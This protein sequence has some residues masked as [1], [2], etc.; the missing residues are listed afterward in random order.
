[1]CRARVNTALLVSFIFFGVEMAL[2]SFALPKYFLSFFFWLDI[3]GT[4]S[5]ILDIPWLFR[6]LGLEKLSTELG[7]VSGAKAARGARAA[8]AAKMARLVRLIRLVRFVRLLKFVAH[9]GR[10]N[11]DDQDTEAVQGAAPPSRIGEILA[12]Q[13]SQR[14]VILVSER[15]VAR[16]RGVACAPHTGLTTIM[17][18][19]FA[20]V[21]AASEGKLCSQRRAALRLAVNA[22]MPD[23]PRLAC[24]PPPGAASAVRGAASEHRPQ[25]R[26]PAADVTDVHGETGP[27]HAC[28]LH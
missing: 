11:K 23:S 6:N 13:M 17:V 15:S 4:V 7:L 1:M 28:E 27:S 2:M 5:L 10:K 16:L 20:F 12:E 19:A 26:L 24:L 9:L 25:R 3:A 8:R 22:L 21:K 18:S 14:V